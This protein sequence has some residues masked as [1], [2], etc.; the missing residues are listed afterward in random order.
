MPLLLL[1]AG[2]TGGC[3]R[4]AGEEPV[5]FP[6]DRVEVVAAY[7]GQRALDSPWRRVLAPAGLLVYS[8]GLVI[9][10]ASRSLR[11]TRS[12]VTTLVRQLRRDLGRHAD[13]LTSPEAMQVLD[14]GSTEFVVRL[15]DGRPHSVTVNQLGIVHDYPPEILDA[16]KRLAD[17]ADRVNADGEQYSSDRVRLVLD[18]ARQPG[19]EVR[20]WPAAL[21]VPPVGRLSVRTADLDGDAARGVI[22]ALSDSG[23][24]TPRRYRL[25]DGAVY[26]VAWRYRAPDED[27]KRR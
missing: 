6:T 15:A 5:D 14:G 23:A 24:D 10:D 26:L 8:D 20:D 17:L 12:Q 7:R 9:L 16:D 13:V 2:V 1:A 25:A 4:R 18:P 3:G 21:A 19:G 22:D 27:I 11:L